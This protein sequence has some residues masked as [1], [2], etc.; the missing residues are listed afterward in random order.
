MVREVLRMGDARLLEHALSVRDFG[1]P[2]LRALVAD[3]WDTMA[4]DGGIGIAA[5]QIGVSE[6]VICFGLEEGA[7]GARAGVPRTVLINP[8]VELLGDETEEGWEGCLSL[9]GLK[10]MVT[11]AKRIRYTGYSLEGERI[12]REAEGFHARVVQHE[13]D[14]LEGILYP[15]R[16]TDWTNFGYTD[17]LVPGTKRLKRRFRMTLLTPFFPQNNSAKLFPSECLT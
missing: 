9:P 10:G 17:A 4:A 14:H 3:L 1:S 5:P 11:R 12:E 15:M 6:R 8:T 16:V 2:R 7:G 13:F